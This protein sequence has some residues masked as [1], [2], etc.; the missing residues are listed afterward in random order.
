MACTTLPVGADTSPSLPGWRAMLR[1][2]ALLAACLAGASAA[3]Q[4]TLDQANA[5][6]SWGGGAHH[7]TTR[8]TQTVSPV[9]ACLTRVEIGI[10]TGNRGK[11][12]D[13]L[14]LT[15]LDWN[16]SPPRQLAKVTANAQEGFDGFLSFA[17]P[18][19]G[20]TVPPHWLALQV[21]DTG[22][23]VFWWKYQLGNP[24]PGGQY[25]FAG[26]GDDTR[27]Y[28]FRTYGRA[29]CSF[30]LAV[31]PDP[32]PVAQG[33]TSIATIGVTRQPGFTA[34][35]DV[36]LALPGGVTASPATLA[37]TGARATTTF[38]ASAGAPI[39]NFP[40][41]AS[42]AASGTSPAQKN[43]RVNVTAGVGGPKVTSVSP[44]V[45]QKGAAITVTGSG[46]DPNCGSNMVGF[47]G[48]NAV[49]TACSAG[50]LTATVPAQAAYGPTTLKVTS[51]GR[52]SNA[53]SFSVGR[54]AG[55]FAE[56]TNDVLQQHTSKTCSGGTVRLEVA[57]SGTAYVA[58]FRKLAG[59]SPIG[60]SIT[61]HPDFWYRDSSGTKYGIN[62]I[63]GVGFSLCSAGLVFDAGDGA[64]PRLFMRDLDRGADFQASPYTVPIQEP[65]L[66]PPFTENYSPRLFR[67]PDGTLL[68]AVT[69]AP[70][71]GTGNVVAAFFD[72][73]A[74]GALLKSVPITR[75]AGS[76]TVGNPAITVTLA[77]DN[78]ITLKF[79]S[80]TLA[81]I[82][83]P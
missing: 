16:T 58:S 69:A 36:S 75:Q 71:N 17:M 26:T 8:S 9:Q 67:S 6:A 33:G 18:G 48:V 77:T 56:I 80:Q 15:V 41:T 28:L 2:W 27:D 66:T 51:G 37:I 21:N 62:H 10:K 68:L 39:G 32:V 73:V 50:S 24:Y 76:S 78:R 57:P 43:F 54:Q 82:S 46:F 30:S 47:G 44:S 81:P 13:Q 64:L 34:R 3:A 20:V 52:T 35:V 60:T 31:T 4:E 5:P 1:R 70:A 12:G 74:G 53:V 23:N 45:Q 19:G 83:V 25:F 72:T 63:G 79:G 29:S 49:P 40:A 65:R 55:S 61:F 38:T 11:G 14:T 42:G 7:V 22:K 59:N